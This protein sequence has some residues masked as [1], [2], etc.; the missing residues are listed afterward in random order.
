MSKDSFELCSNY[1]QNL[2]DKTRKIDNGIDRLS[3]TWKT[4]H[5]LVGGYAERSI[6]VDTCLEELWKSIY[7]TNVSVS[8]T[9]SVFSVLLV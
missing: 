9:E 2:R 5:L 1:F 6:E 3:E 4:P 8:N 7:D